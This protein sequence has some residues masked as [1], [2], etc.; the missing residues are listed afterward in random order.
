[1]K[2]IVDRFFDNQPDLQG[3][4]RFWPWWSGGIALCLV[5]LLFLSWYEGSEPDPFP[6]ASV[7][8]KNPGVIL[9]E[10][11][12]RVAETLYQKPGGYLANDRLP[13]GVFMDDIPNWELGVLQEV[14][15]TTHALGHQ[16]AM[17]HAAL[18]EDADL[19]DAE[20]A[21][22]VDP[23]SWIFPR[24]EKSFREGTHDLQQFSQRLKR[25]DSG[26]VFL[27]TNTA[28]LLYLQDTAQEL[29]QMSALLNSAL[30]QP[31]LEGDRNLPAAA[32]TSWWN[33]DDHFYYVRGQCWA[34]AAILQAIRTEYSG[35]LLAHHADLSLLA[36]IRELQ[37]A[38][39]PVYSPVILNG[40]GFGLFANHS[41]TLANYVDR[42]QLDDQD[43]L[44]LIRTN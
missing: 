43:V 10:T 7:A 22:G 4:R 16:F 14:R 40:S 36:M 20:I 31:E 37:A 39:Q 19:A 13:P 44:A 5:V 24:A 38:G 32:R 12:A 9:T 1:M 23:H 21:F 41:L 18:Q 35:F 3:L 8:D 17:S 33:V 11:M 25:T 42:A 26:A 15:R 28:L 30:P 29:I 6:V 2:G 34:L 27:P